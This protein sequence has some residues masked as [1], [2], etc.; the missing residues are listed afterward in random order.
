MMTPKMK[1][2]ICIR[3]LK[4]SRQ[5]F[6]SARISEVFREK[7][8]RNNWNSWENFFGKSLVCEMRTVETA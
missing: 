4:S 3:I 1:E 2:D 6:L 8:H 7:A 5:L